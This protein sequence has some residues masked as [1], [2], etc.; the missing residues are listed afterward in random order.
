[1]SAGA[2]DV[3]V[4][5]SGWRYPSWRGVFY[6]KGLPQHRELA[7]ASRAVRTIEINDSF[8]SLQRPSRYEAWYRETPPGFVFA[9][10][11]ARFITHNKKLRD[12]EVPLANFFASGV[13]ALEEKL[14]PVLWQLPLQLRFDRERIASFLASLPRTTGEA[15][16]LARRHDHRL[17]HG[18]YLDVRT[19]RSIRDALEVRHESFDDPVL[20]EVLRQ[21]KVALWVT[22]AAA[23]WPRLEDVTAD[24]V[25]V[26]LHGSRRLYASGYTSDELDA[27]AE[28]ID[29]W[30]SGRS[31]KGAK[32]AA[33]GAEP[34]ARHAT[35]TSTSTT[36]RRFARRSTR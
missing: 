24:H 25:Y 13:L 4:G 6:P 9:V 10:K 16:R 1:M 29:A 2:G 33:P 20:P 18:V 12:C 30:R 3:L 23:K 36:T 11:G 14:G 35:S 5:V 27:W 17:E 8:Y 21:A 22:D 28:K 34:A 31:P 7:Y 26:R 19:D 32:L 15:A